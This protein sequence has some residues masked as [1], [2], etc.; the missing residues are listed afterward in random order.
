MYQNM[1]MHVCKKWYCR[2]PILQVL[3][4]FVKDAVLASDYNYVFLALAILSISLLGLESTCTVVI[5]SETFF[6]VSFFITTF[7]QQDFL[8]VFSSLPCFCTFYRPIPTCT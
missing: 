4:H 1:Q 8:V 6:V 2:L 5:D 7:L 3:R